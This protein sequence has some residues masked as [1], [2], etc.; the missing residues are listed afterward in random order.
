MLSVTE[1]VWCGCGVGWCEG[2]GEVSAVDEQARPLWFG[3]VRGGG[4][5]GLTE[6]KFI[7]RGKSYAV[8]GHRHDRN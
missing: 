4:A 8:F 5:P 3:V 2:G 6:L 1:L 7:F